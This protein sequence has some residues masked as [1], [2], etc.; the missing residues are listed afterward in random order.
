EIRN[1]LTGVSL[2]LEK[3]QRLAGPEGSKAAAAAFALIFKGSDLLNEAGQPGRPVRRSSFDIVAAIR[4]IVALLGPIAPEG[5]AMSV[6]ANRPHMVYGNPQEV[7][8]I[9]YN[10]AH[11]AV[12]VARRTRRMHRLDFTVAR[13]ATTL[14]IRISDD[15]PG[16]PHEVRQRLFTG[17][18]GRFSTSGNGFGLAIARE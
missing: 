16:L 15:G 12:S 14:A 6:R 11:N 13:R 17:Q 7:F 4:Q 5:F 10:L 3:L 1:I 18:A 2:H 8:R 9:L